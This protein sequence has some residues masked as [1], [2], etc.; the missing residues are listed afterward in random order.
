VKGMKVRGA[1]I[2]VGTAIATFNLNNGQKYDSKASQPGKGHAAIYISQN[3]AGIQVWDQWVG[4]PVSTR[5]LYFN[6]GVPNTK[7][8]SNDGDQFFVIN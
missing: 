8:N 5:T 2:A 1:N 7:G 3:S 4:H 6:G